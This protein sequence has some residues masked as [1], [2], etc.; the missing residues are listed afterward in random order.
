[1]SLVKVVVTLPPLGPAR[2]TEDVSPVTLSK[3]RFD[4]LTGAASIDEATLI[5]TD[6]TLFGVSIWTLVSPLSLSSLAGAARLPR[7]TY[8]M[9]GVVVPANDVACLIAQI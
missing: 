2:L 3:S 6:P 5:R 7:L 8:L 1:M 4:F 9:A